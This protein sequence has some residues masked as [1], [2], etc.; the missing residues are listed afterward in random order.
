MTR[1][2]RSTMHPPHPA[3]LLHLPF[4]PAPYFSTPGGAEARRAL[5]RRVQPNV[6]PPS[7]TSPTSRPTSDRTSPPPSQRSRKTGKLPGRISPLRT[8]PSKSSLRRAQRDPARR[9]A[10]ARATLVGGLQDP[11]VTPMRRLREKEWGGGRCRS[12]GS[13]SGRAQ[14]VSRPMQCRCVILNTV[15]R[16]RGCG[17]WP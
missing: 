11:D 17:L 3:L 9:P 5:L 7:G 2:A 15:L 10:C 16:P 13:T 12:C 14:L 4:Q 8:S 1:P 6:H